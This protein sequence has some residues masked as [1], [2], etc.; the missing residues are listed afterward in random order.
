MG[1]IEAIIGTIRPKQVDKIIEKGVK[2]PGISIA[3]IS[4]WKFF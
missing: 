3:V 1:N 4:L 2:N